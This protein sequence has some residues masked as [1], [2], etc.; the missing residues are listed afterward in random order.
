[1]KLKCVELEI[2]RV[3]YASYELKPSMLINIMINCHNAI[4]NLV[5][6]FHYDRKMSFIKKIQFYNILIQLL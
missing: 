3:R 2:C 4:L 1:M 5:W 6:S